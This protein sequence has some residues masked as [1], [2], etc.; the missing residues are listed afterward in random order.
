[1]NPA[2]K[3][4]GSTQHQT[5]RRRT[6]PTK[7]KTPA[8]S[9]HRQQDAQSDDEDSSSDSTYRDSSSE[10]STS[11]G[12]ATDSGSSASS[13]DAYVSSISSSPSISDSESS[14][15]TDSSRSDSQRSSSPEKKN[16]QNKRSR[17]RQRT[18][19]INVR[20][21][22]KDREELERIIERNGKFD[23]ARLKRKPRPLSNRDYE[24]INDPIARITAKTQDIIR[25]HWDRGGWKEFQKTPG[26]LPLSKPL[27]TAIAKNTTVGLGE[28]LDESIIEA[29]KY[30]EPTV[31]I[32]SSI[33]I[34]STP[35]KSRSITNK[36]L[37]LAAFNRYKKA[38]L[39]LYSHRE[40][41]LEEYKDQIFRLFADYPFQVVAAY[42]EEK[43][44]SLLLHRE[45]TL[46]TFDHR[47][48]SKHFNGATPRLQNFSQQTM[49]RPNP[50]YMRTC[51]DWNRASGR[52]RFG[53]RCQYAHRCYKCNSSEHSGSACPD[54]ATENASA[55]TTGV[56]RL[57][58]G[59]SSRSRGEST[60]SAAK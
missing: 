34:G 4:K 58:G 17:R 27:W 36:F 25:A 41:E 32:G 18:E 28:F 51:R 10:K 42:D 40:Y 35:R 57:P 56:G 8:R 52:C 59:G 46:L 23:I 38:V 5:K 33:T 21:T 45:R 3:K 24:D 50:V 53:S 12:S 9:G 26:I 55:A 29:A 48:E 14:T 6:V 19:K 7:P 22:R 31:T 37:W 30:V 13:S 60:Q 16:R 44:T 20:I 49:S 2:V 43:R 1:M 11:T 39:T 47:I 54:R 15:F